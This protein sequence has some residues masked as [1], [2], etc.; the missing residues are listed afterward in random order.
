MNKKYVI[1]ISIVIGLWVAF[2]AYRHVR[3]KRETEDFEAKEYSRVT[4]IAKQSPRAGLGQMGRALQKYYEEK[5]A[6]PSRL[7]ELY[8]EYLGNKSFIE[9]IDWYYEPKGDNFYLSKT[10]TRDNRRM[11]ASIDKGLM[12]R[13]ETG[14]MVAAPTPTP[15]PGEVERPEGIVAERPAISIRSREEF[16]DALRLS[17]KGL[18]PASWAKRDKLR[19]ISSIRP[20]IVS[21]ETYEVSSSV[22]AKLSQRYLVWKDKNGILGFGNVAYPAAKRQTVYAKGSWYD[23][24]VP[25]PKE[26]GPMTPDAKTAKKEEGHEVIASSLSQRYLVWK[27]REG[28]LGFGNVG[29]PKRDRVSVF[30]DDSW[31]GVKRPV[32]PAE[33]GK[34]EAY[35][36][37]KDKSVDMM[38]SELSTRYLV[39]KDKHGTL[40]FGN[41]RYPETKNISHVHVNGIW[42]KVIN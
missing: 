9:E 22:E 11:I 5:R 17:Q 38:A 14:V 31:V 7:Q 4:I 33:T 36:P 13:V 25:L 18:T 1:A 37:E 24:K 42:E 41:V 32:L 2:M 15:K 10:V 30:Q 28:I 6:Y 40:G 3:G 8:P 12:P 19:I 34:E 29:Y 23:I 35:R 39:W 26:E 21:V 27:S 20:E 16:W